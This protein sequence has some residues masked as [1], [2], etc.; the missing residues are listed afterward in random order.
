MENERIVLRW[1]IYDDF[2]SRLGAGVSSGVDAVV[3]LFFEC[4]DVGAGCL[5]DIICNRAR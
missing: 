1:N 5:V 3:G 4:S 2:S